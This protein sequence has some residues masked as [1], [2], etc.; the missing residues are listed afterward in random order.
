[1][2][3]RGILDVRKINDV[4]FNIIYKLL[5]L[6]DRLLLVQTQSWFIGKERRILGLLLAI[7]A[8]VIGGQTYGI[9]GAII[10]AGIGTLSGV[11]VGTLVSN[12]YRKRYETK[13]DTLLENLRILSID[14]I[15][16]SSKYFQLIYSNIKMIQ[17]TLDKSSSYPYLRHNGTLIIEADKRYYFVIINSIHYAERIVSTILPQQYSYSDWIKG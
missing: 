6:D 7:I 14:E 1:L 12:V 17:V 3:I 2:D 8:G 15:K 13:T 11:F 5:F 16:K 10:G 9:F 4:H